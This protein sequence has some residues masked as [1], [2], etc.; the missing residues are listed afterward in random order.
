MPKKL[1]LSF[2]PTDIFQLFSEANSLTLC[3]CITTVIGCW[4]LERS[5]PWILLT[6][7]PKRGFL[8]V[9]EKAIKKICSSGM[10]GPPWPIYMFTKRIINHDQITCR[11]SQG[12]RHTSSADKPVLAILAISAWVSEIRKC[13]KGCLVPPRRMFCSDTDFTL[14][15]WYSTSNTLFWPNLIIISCIFRC[16]RVSV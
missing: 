6:Q 2:F 10:Q 11:H 8:P 5:Y 16:D 1:I 14:H 15:L 9:R 3:T 4:L 7:N 12:T 13:D